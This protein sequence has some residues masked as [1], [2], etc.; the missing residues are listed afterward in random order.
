[1]PTA[2][3]YTPRTSQ[4]AATPTA[5]A[6]SLIPNEG[7]KPGESIQVGRRGAKHLAKDGFIRVYA[8]R[9]QAQ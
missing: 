8:N 6:P 2:P 3:L 7:L 1:M 4:H 5:T 9:T